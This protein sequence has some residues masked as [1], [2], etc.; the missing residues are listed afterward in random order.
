MRAPL[1]HSNTVRVPPSPSAQP[2]FC[3]FVRGGK[4]INNYR[5]LDAFPTSVHFFSLF[6]ETAHFLQLLAKKVKREKRKNCKLLLSVAW[7]QAVRAM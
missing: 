1:G 2:N 3:I 5:Q 4:A 6:L 7:S